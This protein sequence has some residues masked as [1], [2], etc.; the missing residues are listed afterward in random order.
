MTTYKD[1]I[2]EEEANVLALREM[3]YDI[4]YR[5]DPTGRRG[6]YIKNNLKRAFEFLKYAEEGIAAMKAQK[7][8]DQWK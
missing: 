3:T 2:L 6:G 7:R 5:M 8:K 1:R 4:I